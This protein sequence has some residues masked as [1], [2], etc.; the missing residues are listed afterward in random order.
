MYYWARYLKEISQL[1]SYL[2]CEKS[3]ELLIKVPSLIPWGS[4][5]SVT[6]TFAEVKTKREMEKGRLFTSDLLTVLGSGVLQTHLKWCPVSLLIAA[7][8]LSRPLKPYQLYHPS[9]DSPTK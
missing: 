6:A 4:V 3:N 2:L 1:E 8:H 7:P 9:P 5:A